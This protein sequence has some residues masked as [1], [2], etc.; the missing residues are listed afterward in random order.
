MYMCMSWVR[1]RERV[2]PSARNNYV[3]RYDDSSANQVS[4]EE[5]LEVWLVDGQIAS[6][7]REAYST[8]T[9]KVLSR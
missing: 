5:R 8:F 1:G 6:V 7:H 9:E 4:D 2:S 3:R